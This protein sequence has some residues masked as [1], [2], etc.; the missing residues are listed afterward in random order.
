[1]QI[2]E[3][4]KIVQKNLSE[5][6]YYHSKCVQKRCKQLALIYKVDVEI[7]EKVGIMHDIAKEMY[8]DEKLQYVERNHIVIDEIERKNPELLHAK[9]GAH[10]S[11]KL[12][13]FTEQMAR[14]I[15]AH[16]TGKTNMDIL[17][18]ILFVADATGEDRTFE[19]VERLRKKSETNLDEVIIYIIEKNIVDNLKKG[20]LVHPD[21]IYARNELVSK[22]MVVS[23]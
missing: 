19:N 4:E 14:A 21:G 8:E 12:Y 5:Y 10:M 23:L 11:K 1:M 17:A 9:I 22:N 13:G 3:L 16:T 15:Q 7:A 18:K 6:R 2:Q 20:R